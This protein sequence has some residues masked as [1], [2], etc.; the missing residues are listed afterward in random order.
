[1]QQDMIDMKQKLDTWNK[2]IEENT[3]WNNTDRQELNNFLYSL[4]EDS[5]WI[6]RLSTSDKNLIFVSESGEEIPFPVKYIRHAP[7]L[8]PVTIPLISG[9][10]PRDIVDP[11]F[12]IGTGGPGLDLDPP[13]NKFELNGTSI[14]R[15]SSK[16]IRKFIEFCAIMDIGSD[17]K[18]VHLLT[19][20]DLERKFDSFPQNY[21]N[22]LN[23]LIESPAAAAS[24]AGAG[25]GAGAGAGGGGGPNPTFD[26]YR[27]S[28]LDNW[29]D[30]LDSI[31]VNPDEHDRY[32]EPPAGITFLHD[33]IDCMKFLECPAVQNLCGFFCIKFLNGKTVDQVR[34]NL[35]IVNDFTPEEQASID[36]E[37]AWLNS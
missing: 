17:G 16:C 19:S 22:L 5:A 7:Y 1:M 3:S 32:P 36:A 8:L 14:K 33:M 6:Y 25:G 28:G 4:R 13:N 31:G 11:T 26:G 23:S 18:Y 20:G 37:E 27:E 10:E 24:G 34:T 35:G 9:V 30:Y 29:I 2:S 15:I 12:D 21:K